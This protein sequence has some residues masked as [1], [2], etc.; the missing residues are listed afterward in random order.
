[1]S[2]LKL[3]MASVFT[4]LVVIGGGVFSGALLFR[5]TPALEHVAEAGDGNPGQVGSAE[6]G[7][8]GR[9]GFVHCMRR[10]TPLTPDGKG[11]T[12]LEENPPEGE[13]IIGVPRLD[14]DGK[15]LAYLTNKP[16]GIW[17]K[18][19]GKPGPG[20]QTG[21]RGQNYFWSPDGQQLA[22]AVCEAV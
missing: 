9:G 20:F 13:Y 8:E 21:A 12:W 1:Q 6:G 15:R 10:L 7:P 11:L 3:I 19:I 14:R 16:G 5:S 18:D 4:L 22:V 2:K 17:V